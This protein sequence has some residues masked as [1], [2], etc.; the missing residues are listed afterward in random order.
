MP[1]DNNG[2]IPL[3]TCAM[4]GTLAVTPPAL[5][6]A[7]QFQASVPTGWIVTFNWFDGGRTQANRNAPWVE[8]GAGL[9][10]CAYKIGQIPDEAV[11]YADRFRYAV[12]IGQKTVAKYPQKTIDLDEA[13]NPILR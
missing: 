3:D 9:D 1:S 5:D 4:P 7:K 8:T 12:L 13:G 2:R 6:L 11:H 10:L